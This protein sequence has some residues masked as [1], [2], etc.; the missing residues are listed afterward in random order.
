MGCLRNDDGCFRDEI[1]VH[2][3]TI[4][5][6]ALSKHEVTFNDWDACVAAGGCGGH[7]PDDERWGRG[8][9]PVINVSWED[10]QSFVAWLSEVTG[11][12]YRLPTESEW[13]YSARAGTETEYSWG[14]GI[15]NNRANCSGCG[16]RWGR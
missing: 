10:A 8:D 1:P 11:H 5:S 16:S 12:A 2:E 13:E 15:G 4:P 14:N 3:V 7:R 9:R 6:F